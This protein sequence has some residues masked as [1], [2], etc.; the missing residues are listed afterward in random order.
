ML[1]INFQDI[2]SLITEQIF[3]YKGSEV[4]IKDAEFIQ[5]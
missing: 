3:S 2:R 4:I 1:F 5:N